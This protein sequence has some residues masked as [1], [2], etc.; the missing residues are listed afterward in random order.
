MIKVQA[1]ARL[2]QLSLNS[3][4][5]LLSRL[6]TQLGMALFTILLARDLGSAGFGQYA[7][8]A[9]VIVVGNVLTT[10]GT[11]ML[12]IREIAATGKLAGLSAALVLQLALSVPFVAIVFAA[13]SQLGAL[14]PEAQTA[15]RIYSLSMAPLA[16]FTV[17][18]T[19]LRGRQHMLSYAMLNLALML[20]QLA[21]AG[22][23]LSSRGGLAELAMLL[24]AVQVAAAVL[25]GALCAGRIADFRSAWQVPW[26]ELKPLMRVSAPIALLGVLGVA[27]QR[28]SLL[29]LPML[30]G[31]AATGWYSAGARLIEAA[32]I[33]HIAVFTAIYPVMAEERDAGKMT[34]S[35]DF[36]W[37]GLLLLG[38]AS[39]A[40]LL[41]CL[42]AAPIITLPFGE[43][44]AEAVPA[45]RVLAWLLP[46][47]TINSFLTLA[48][49]ARGHERVIAWVLG[50]S[51]VTLA[52][53]TLW[54]APLAGATGA[55]WAALS[56]EV[57]QAAALIAVDAR[58]EGV[59]RRIMEGE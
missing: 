38:A 1:N 36:R 32:K 58:G 7:F 48:L 43:Q 30:A 49:L 21:A 5:L 35:R 9:S 25:A 51:I 33:G 56:A 42:L 59:V 39:A 17:F 8:I 3:L 15:L 47:Y 28:F 53:L 20:M 26:A 40:S 23:L 11:D 57:V 12:L 14:Q 22:W 24:L 55:A 45:V 46:A 18:T 27:Y 19:A 10:F 54:W 16:F 52:V 34:W 44:Y 29:A 4:W 6:G 31:A 13:G 50:F 2:T 37:P 41:L